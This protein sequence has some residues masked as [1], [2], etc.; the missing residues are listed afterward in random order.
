M[1]EHILTPPLIIIRLFLRDLIE[2]LA[3]CAEGRFVLLCTS[4]SDY[5]DESTTKCNVPSLFVREHSRCGIRTTR[6]LNDT[7]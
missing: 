2:I 7:F 5:G 6:W 4:H 1:M 3:I